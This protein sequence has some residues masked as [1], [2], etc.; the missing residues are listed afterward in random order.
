MTIRYI[1][2]MSFLLLSVAFGI[3]GDWFA[4]AACLVCMLL[5]ANNMVLQLHVRILESEIITADFETWWELEGKSNS[6]F[7]S[8][9]GM[10]SSKYISQWAW[11]SAKKQVND[12]G[13]KGMK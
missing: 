10:G 4:F 12:H 13:R 9:I 7:M 8:F 3:V 6:R 2:A 5:Q 1:I 11:L